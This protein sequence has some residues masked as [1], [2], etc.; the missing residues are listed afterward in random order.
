[1]PRKK[2]VTKTTKTTK[3]ARTT[4]TTKT[5]KVKKTAA[6][7]KQSTIASVADYLKLGESYTSLVLGMIAVIIATVL[8]LSFVHS[9]QGE[10]LTPEATPTIV[11]SEVFDITPT[12]VAINKPTDSQI[13]TVPPSPTEKVKQ[14][15][16]TAKGKM[17]VVEEGDNL[18]IIAEKVYGSGYN[19]VDIARANNLSNPSDIHVGNELLTP[20]VAL[21]EA[22]V[23]TDDE[24]LSRSFQPKIVGNTYK[25]VPGDNLWGIALRAYGD[26]YQWTKIAKA[27]NLS[28][29]NY[30]HTGNVLKI[31]R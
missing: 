31:P 13:P 29:P 22:T 11:Q 15:E 1:M 17:Y 5:A 3:A 30:I 18:W 26:G 27:N 23:Q 10:R 19:W 24:H 14:T 9:K 25:V 2:A 4:K 8:L 16:K 21:K 7:R 28:D 6:P 20:E 12:G